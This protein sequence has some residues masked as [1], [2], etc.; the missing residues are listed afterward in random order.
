MW[1]TESGRPPIPGSR[2][3][4][5]YALKWNVRSPVRPDYD[6]LFK[7]RSLA[8]PRPVALRINHDRRDTITTSADPAFRLLC[9]DVGLWVEYDCLDDA[10]DEI[11]R[12]VRFGQFKAWSISFGATEQRWDR[13]GARTLRIIQSAN[14]GEVSIADR[15][16]HATTIGILSRMQPAAPAL[17]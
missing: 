16:A 17:F 2:T 13:K 4:C 12:G 5:G 8:F 7:P 6:E 1:M 3:I 9:D 15:G 10:G 11:L 14:L